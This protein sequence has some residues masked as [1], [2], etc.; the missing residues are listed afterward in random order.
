LAKFTSRKYL[1]KANAGKKRE[2][3]TSP[4]KNSLD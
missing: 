1:E 4:M 3:S 2:L